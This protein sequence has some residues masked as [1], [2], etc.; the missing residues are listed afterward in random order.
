MSVPI[1]LCGHH[2]ASVFFST[3]SHRTDDERESVLYLNQ[4]TVDENSLR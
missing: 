3:Y 2:S 4:Q 1:P